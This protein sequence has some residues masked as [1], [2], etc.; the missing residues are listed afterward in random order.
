MKKIL[1]FF[2]VVLLLNS[3]LSWQYPVENSFENVT[4]EM[5]VQEFKKNHSDPKFSDK[6]KNEFFEGNNQIYSIIFYKKTG[7]AMGSVSDFTY[8]KYYYF[9]NDKLTKVD[10]GERAVDLRIKID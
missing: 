4:P 7:D 2:I 8:K 3:C 6:V 1:V 5:T 9:E 10:R